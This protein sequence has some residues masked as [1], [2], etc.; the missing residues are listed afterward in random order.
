M[1][2]LQVQCN[3][4][5]SE[6]HFQK[7]KMFTKNFI[8]NSGELCS[9]INQHYAQHLCAT[10]L[11]FFGRVLALQHLKK[12]CSL[13]SIEVSGIVLPFVIWERTHSQVNSLPFFYA[14]NLIKKKCNTWILQLKWKEKSKLLSGNELIQYNIRTAYKCAKL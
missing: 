1:E 9:I 13:G 3:A 5:G 4:H 6:Q 14:S 10:I 12:I 11:P 7:I 2:V 8:N